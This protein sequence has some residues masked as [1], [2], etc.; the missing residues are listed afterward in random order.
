ML[1]GLHIPEL[2]GPLPPCRTFF[3][4]G[5]KKHKIIESIKFA[6]VILIH[7]VDLYLVSFGFGEVSITLWLCNKIFIKTASH[8]S[9]FA[10]TFP[11]AAMETLVLRCQSTEQGEKPTREDPKLTDSHLHCSLTIGMG[12]RMCYSLAGAGTL[13]PLLC[14]QWSPVPL[15]LWF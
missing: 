7:H 10:T 6:G 1:P 15:R 5:F 2:P 3:L 11:P 14:P 4:S 9:H 12:L 8:C 13:P